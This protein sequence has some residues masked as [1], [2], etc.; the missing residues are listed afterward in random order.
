MMVAQRLMVATQP[1][2]LCEPKALCRPL[3]LCAILPRVT[4]DS[5]V[6]PPTAR[7]NQEPVTLTQVTLPAMALC[8]TTPGSLQT[9]AASTDKGRPGACYKN[10]TES[11]GTEDTTTAWKIQNIRKAVGGHVAVRLSRFM[12]IQ[13]GASQ[14]MICDL[15]TTWRVFQRPEDH[16][17][18]N[19]CVSLFLLIPIRIQIGGG[20]FIKATKAQ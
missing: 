5:S 15:Q 12:R 7:I 13:T 9:R 14:S 18:L 19:S 8:T 17:Y 11:L 1:K 16:C 4:S 6:A 20:C 2:V 10:V 3:G